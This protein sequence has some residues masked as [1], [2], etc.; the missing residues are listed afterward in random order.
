MQD[1]VKMEKFKSV[2]F[3]GCDP[4]TLKSHPSVFST[5]KYLNENQV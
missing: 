5:Y 2:D 4:Q 3:A 1:K